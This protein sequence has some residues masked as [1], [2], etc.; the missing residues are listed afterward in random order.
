M[1]LFLVIAGLILLLVHPPLFAGAA[2]A[3]AICLIVAAVITVIQV[4]LFVFGARKIKR[5]QDEFRRDP[6]GRSRP[7][8]L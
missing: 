3:G 4:A 6:F 7:P 5:A 8:R 2:T 1:Q